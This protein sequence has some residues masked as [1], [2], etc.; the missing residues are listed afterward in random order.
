MADADL[1]RPIVTQAPA[2]DHAPAS[3]PRPAI[4]SPPRANA[5]RR[6]A[7]FTAILAA[8]GEAASTR[9]V[10]VELPVALEFNGIGYAV[11]MATPTDLED[12]VTGFAIAERLVAPDGRLADIAIAE[13]EGG[14]VVRGRLEGDATPVFERAR[15]RV[16]E[17]SCGLCG[18]ENLAE[19][20][21]ALPPVARPLDLGAD[22]LFTALAAL[23]P[24]QSL[25]NAT[26]AAHAAALCR[27]DGTLILLREDVGRHNALDKAIGARARAAIAGD[28]FA[29]VTARCSYELVEKAVTAGL[30]ALVAISAPTTLALDRARAAGLP[31]YVLARDD[32]VL[33]A[34]P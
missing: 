18:I 9:A 19:V 22:A 10:P 6:E 17:S 24:V 16:A 12:F 29:L 11:M 13:V 33:R 32:A 27:P 1:Q 8:G 15:R 23:R 5:D 2:R 4:S 7:A 30:G 25:G 34:D 20:N 14:V 28:A 21:R 26:R 3:P 31:L